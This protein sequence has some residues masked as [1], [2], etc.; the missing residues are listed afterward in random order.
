[1]VD[2]VA[3]A[4]PD[5]AVS[6]APARG[7]GARA[8]IHFDNSTPRGGLKKKR[9][10][11]I[12]ET[13]RWGRK[14]IINETRVDRDAMNG[15]SGGGVGCWKGLDEELV[16]NEHAFEQE[17]VPLLLHLRMW[18][19]LRGREGR[20]R[21]L[22]GCVREGV[23]RG[24]VGIC[25]GAGGSGK[26]DKTETEPGRQAKRKGEKG[27]GGGEKGREKREREREGEGVERVMSA[28]RK[29][30][31]E[32]PRLHPRHNHPT[33]APVTTLLAW[34]IFHPCLLHPH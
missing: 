31:A 28:T 26:E 27:E 21:V 10:G 12:G 4:L 3:A 6:L 25:S 20:V 5:A 2:P 14:R 9:G 16:R 7:V 24:M 17:H 8:E 19:E 1:M 32:L 33:A 22:R 23:G 18:V 29:G 13:G 11:R 15:G 34:T 30:N